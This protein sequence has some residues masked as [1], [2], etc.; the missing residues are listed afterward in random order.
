[1]EQI[2]EVDLLPGQVEE[3]ETITI[4]SPVRKSATLTGTS[5]E[6]T[7]TLTS[8]ERRG[9]ERKTSMV[10]VQKFLNGHSGMTT[11]RCWIVYFSNRQ[12]IVTGL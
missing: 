7:E 8:P 9:M 11:L 4:N 1:M 5:S 2:G 6:I 10:R 12:R 3:E